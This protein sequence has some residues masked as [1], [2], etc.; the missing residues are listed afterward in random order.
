VLLFFRAELFV[1]GVETGFFS[2]FGVGTGFFSTFGVETGFFSTFGAGT[3]FFST[4]GVMGSSA[5]GFS[6]AFL[7]ERFLRKCAGI[8]FIPKTSF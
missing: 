3:D 5:F 8:F 4:F 7:T 1:F 6:T 2:T